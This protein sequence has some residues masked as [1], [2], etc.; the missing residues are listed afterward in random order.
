[1]QGEVVYL[2]AFDV[3]NEI[4][5]ARVQEILSEKPFPFEIRMDRTLPK[6]M[7]LYKPLAIEPHLLPAKLYGRE[8][9]FLI[10]VYDVGVVTVMMRV[11]IAVA[12][13]G[14]LT[15]FHNPKLENGEVLDA[16]ALKLCAQV[17]ES[18]KD[19]LLGKTEFPPPPEA[20]T[21]F[22]LTDLDGMADANQWLGGH[23]REVAGLLT[24]TAPNHL[25]ESQVG[26]VLRIQKSFEN[27]D[28]AV[29]DWD[30]ALVVD[31]TGY[32]DD[33]LYALELA[34]LQLEEFRV[35]DRRL[36]AYLDRAYEDLERRPMPMF[37]A[38][39]KTLRHLRRFRVDVAKLADEVTHITKFFGDWH[40]ARVYLGARDRFYLDQWR[41]SVEQ[42][43]AQLDKLYS[44]VHA[45]VN[46]QRM[47]WLEIIIVIFFAF[48]LVILLVVKH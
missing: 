38:A 30:A 7:P 47:L 37:G 21:V 27:T 18:L 22:C 9:S 8:V 19:L 36:D 3:A 34:N 41:A 31:L 29:I 2:Y 46:E 14:D 11:S 25:S 32:T 26:E 6:D 35:M 39:S 45:E 5:T 12:T 33:V 23:R 28:L 40:L 43:L 4:I 1:M 17:C 42:R 48:D 24:E 10:R 13:L 16:V 20:Y 15:P 44:V